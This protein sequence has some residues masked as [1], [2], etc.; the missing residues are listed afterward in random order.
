MRIN[1]MNE[2]VF[3]SCCLPT[4]QIRKV[5]VI[6]ASLVM[7]LTSIIGNAAG[8]YHGP[9]GPSPITNLI[10]S[11]KV[12]FSYALGMKTFQNKCSACHGKWGEGVADKGPPLVHRF[13]EPSHHGDEAF[14]RAVKNGTKQH[15]WKFGD[16]PPVPDISRKQTSNI[17]RFIRWWQQQ[18]GIK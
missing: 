7:L 5:A 13:Y 6:T 4:R 10:K 12:P 11:P 1:N 9:A 3:T 18:H 16:M 14:Y 15:H 17:V 8:M 2:I